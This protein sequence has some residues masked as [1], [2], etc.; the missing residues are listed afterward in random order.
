MKVADDQLSDDIQT[1]Q[2]FR[3]ARKAD[4]DGERTIGECCSRLHTRACSLTHWVAA[5]V[6]KPDLLGDGSTGLQDEWLNI[7]QGRKHQLRLGY[8]A[9]LLPDDKQ[10]KSGL[11]RAQLDVEARNWFSSKHP[12][13]STSP[14]RLGIPNVVSDISRLLMKIIQDS[15]VPLS[16]LAGP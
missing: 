10:R 13:K 14:D 16:L 15:Y 3:L 2:A 9:V 11:S 12:W 7:L 4:P 6:T 1:V 5:V 8:Y